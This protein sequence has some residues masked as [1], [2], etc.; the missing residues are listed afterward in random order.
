MLL[1]QLSDYLTSLSDYMPALSH[2]SP[3]TLVGT[4]IVAVCTLLYFFTR[5]PEYLLVVL[6]ALLYAAAPLIH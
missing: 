5:V 2:I 4:A 1:D 6:T 3:V